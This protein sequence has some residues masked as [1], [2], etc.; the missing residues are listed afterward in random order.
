M[1]FIADA[2][3]PKPAPK[4][5][6]DAGMFDDNAHAYVYGQK[7]IRMAW[8]GMLGAGLDGN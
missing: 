2:I 4:Y 8:Q 1:H 3:K 5:S 7:V 6:S